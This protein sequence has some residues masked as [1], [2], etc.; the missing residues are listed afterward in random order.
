MEIKEK[1]FQTYQRDKKIR[2]KVARAGDS[3]GKWVLSCTVARDEKW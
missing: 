3:V 2:S 1:P